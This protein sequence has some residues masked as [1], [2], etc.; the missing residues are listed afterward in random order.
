[1]NAE[2]EKQ[3]DSQQRLQKMIRG[4]LLWLGVT[5]IALI[6][7]AIL[8]SNLLAANPLDITLGE[9][10]GQAVEANESITYTSRV[11]TQRARDEAAAAVADVYDF[12]DLSIGASQISK[13]RALFNFVEVVRADNLAG[14]DDKKEYLLAIESVNVDPQVAEDLL[15]M[16]QSEFSRVRADVLRIIEDAMRQQIR[17]HEV[18]EARRTARGQISF[19]WTPAQERAVTDLSPQF[20]VANSFLN[21]E[22]TAQRRAEAIAGVEPV[23]V[24]VT[25][26]ETIIQVGRVI[27][28]VDIETLERLGLLQRQ[29]DW[30]Q[31]TSF[32]LVSLLAVVIVALYW[33]QFHHSLTQRTRFLIIFI[34]LFLLFI[35]G[36]RLMIP[37]QEWLGYLFPAAA[38]SMLL[39]VIYEVRFSILVT[40]VMAILVGVMGRDSLELALYVA[41][42]GSMAALAL[43]DTQRISALFRAGMAAA[44]A[45]LLVILVFHLPGDTPVIDLAQLLLA[46]VANGLISA[47]LTLAGFYIIGG[48]FGVMTTLQLQDLSRLDHPLLQDL[49]RRAPG[50]YHHSIMVANLAEQAAER[51]RANSSLVRVGAFYHDIGK[52]NRPLFFTENQEGISPHQTLD[53]YSSARII[54]SHVTDGL[55]LAKRYR[56]P[57]RIRDFI[58]EHHG[59]RVLKPFYQ[60]ARESAG[61]N[62]DEVD[63]ERFRYKGPRPRCRET[64]IVQLADSIEATSSALRPDTEAAIEKLVTG[65]VEEHLKESQLDNSGLTLGDLKQLRESFIETLKGRFHMRVRYPGNEELEER[66]IS[67]PDESEEAGQPERDGEGIPAAQEEVKE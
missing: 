35:A 38:L 11:L 24:T 43:H 51:I 16:S 18:S 56:L 40:F 15:T 12:P 39:A 58:A 64:A 9:R 65:L 44:V 62:A 46:A 17:E 6:T 13:A 32:F 28:E 52:M 63:V 60:K 21:E 10:A 26:G 67:R 50:T 37:G 31:I 8:A 55:E 34:A 59:T 22:L 48:L 61:D 49:L 27:D 53:P 23:Q 29:I 5:L 14:F 57:L 19:D 2:Q 36:A 4:S 45:N 41:A 3:S 47:S 7:T 66:Q 20:I 54:I 25:R 33:E 1:M 30:R 42:G